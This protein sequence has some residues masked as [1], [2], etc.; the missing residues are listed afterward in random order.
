[1]TFGTFMDAPGDFQLFTR[2]DAL[3]IGG[4]DEDMMLGWHCD[5]NLNKRLMML[6]GKTNDASNYLDGFHCDHTRQVTPMHKS[7]SKSNDLK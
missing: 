7:G 3:K 6:N 5:S 1:M 4:F 2:E